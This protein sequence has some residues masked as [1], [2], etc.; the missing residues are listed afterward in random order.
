MALVSDGVQRATVTRVGSQSV[1]KLK[2][3]STDR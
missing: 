2:V 1:D 3:D